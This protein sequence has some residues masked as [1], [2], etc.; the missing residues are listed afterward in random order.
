MKKRKIYLILTVLVIVVS[1]N[2]RKKQFENLL[3]T[4]NIQYWNHEWKRNYPNEFGETFSFSKNGNLLKYFYLKESGLR[5]IYSEDN[6]KPYR[7]RITCDSIL[8]FYSA[9]LIKTESYQ[10]LQFNNDS[11]K[12]IDLHS[13]DTS[14]LYKVKQSFNILVEMKPKKFMLN[15]Q[16]KDTILILTK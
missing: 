10:I 11:I 1:C 12:L 7:W 9:E 16:T 8:Q 3:S 15:E 14:V 6:E 2:N 4:G 13:K 5:K